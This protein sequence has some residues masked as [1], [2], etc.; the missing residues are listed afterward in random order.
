MDRFVLALAL[1]AILP[2]CAFA[3]A[4][5]PALPLEFDSEAIHLRIAG[6]SLEVD[7]T[8]WLVCS[9]Q[10]GS[11]GLIYPFP[12][13][14]R[15]GGAR[16]L[17]VEI[18]RPG[19]AWVPVPYAM[20]PAGAALRCRVP[21]LAAD[22]LEFHAVYRQAL[23]ERYARYIVTTTRAWGRPLRRALFTITLPEGARLGETSYPFL[24]DST[25]EQ[26]DADKE[27]PG[28][29]RYVFETE[30]FWPERDIIVQWDTPASAA[31]A[32]AAPAPA[33]AHTPAPAS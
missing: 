15:M 14:P 30:S 29:R 25:A 31:P 9:A 11:M 10:E 13:D 6:D 20:L 22:T 4:N 24:P 12:A 16:A 7:G 21:L 32:P 23:L 1:L 26:D 3:Q 28:P 2:P 19:G 18:R 5:A 17:T 8:Y 27:A 33:P